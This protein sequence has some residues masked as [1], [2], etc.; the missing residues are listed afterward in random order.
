MKVYRSL[1]EIK[2]I[3]N[4]IVTQGTFDGVHAAHQVILAQL[5]KI[6]K[7]NG[8]RIKKYD[9]IYHL[10]EDLQK[11][12]M[13]LIEPSI[14]EIPLGEAEVLQVFEMKGDRIAGCRVKT[15]EI[16]KTD[17]YHLKRDGKVIMDPVLKSMMRGKEEITSCKAKSECGLTFRKG[18]KDFQVGDILVAYK[19]E[20]DE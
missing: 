11:Q 14:D 16:K 3:N 2:K 10:I 4:A 7:E 17:K 13:K 8:V 12:M 6:A 18:A 5:K 19:L 15:G 9:V 1:D 20:D